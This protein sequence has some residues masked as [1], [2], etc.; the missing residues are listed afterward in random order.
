L[1]S[2]P[3]FLKKGCLCTD[4]LKKEG[5]APL[6]KKEVCDFAGVAMDF[7]SATFISWL[8]KRTY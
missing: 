1:D 6:L 4:P 5:S 2:T 3:S 8:V 7:V